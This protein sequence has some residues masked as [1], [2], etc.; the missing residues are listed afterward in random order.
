MVTGR[1]YKN[2]DNYGLVS[3]KRRK[4]ILLGQR[5]Q[6]RTGYGEVWQV[7]TGQIGNKKRATA[8]CKRCRGYLLNGRCYG[9]LRHWIWA[10]RGFLRETDAFDRHKTEILA[11]ALHYCFEKRYGYLVDSFVS[12]NDYVRPQTGL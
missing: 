1:H 10:R 8:D 11:N 5:V 6:S 9:S 2:E 3:C 4:R 7:P 12:M